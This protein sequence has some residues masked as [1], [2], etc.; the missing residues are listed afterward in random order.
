MAT[1]RRRR[2]TLHL[3]ACAAL[4]AGAFVVGCKSEPIPTAQDLFAAGTVRAEQTIRD[5]VAD[6]ERRDQALDIV[7]KY[8]AA[9]RE[10]LD[11]TVRIRD[12]IVALNRDYG[13]TREKYTEQRQLLK[14]RREAFSDTMVSAWMSLTDVLEADEEKALIAQQQKE[15][16]RW[17][18]K[19]K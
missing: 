11:G 7:T 13:A 6:P 4:A 15:D 14:A 19:I 5:T 1:S 18:H 3:V 17:R 12:Q 8:A 16:E 2:L 10:F 9:E